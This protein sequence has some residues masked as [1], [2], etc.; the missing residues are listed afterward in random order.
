MLQ[1]SQLQAIHKLRY[2]DI[3]P[4]YIGEWFW[5]RSPSPSFNCTFKDPFKLL[6]N[7][8]SILAATTHLLLIYSHLIFILKILDKS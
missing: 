7:K 6:I 4:N 5:S 8:V 3:Q 1:M 2:V